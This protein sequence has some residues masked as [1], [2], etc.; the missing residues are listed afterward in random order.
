MKK[1][2]CL[3][4]F[5]FFS[6]LRLWCSWVFQQYNDTKLTSTLVKE[7]L[8]QVR[9]VKMSTYR[10]IDELHRFCQKELLKIQTED[11]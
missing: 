4:F 3:F 9:I 1:E 8:S 6:R 5:L 2:D 7:R 10:H 11:C